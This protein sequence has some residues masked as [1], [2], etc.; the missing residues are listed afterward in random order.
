MQKRKIITTPFLEMVLISNGTH[1]TKCDFLYDNEAHQ[2]YKEIPLEDDPILTE[3]A[4]QLADY[5]AQK[6]HTFDLPLKPQGTNFQQKVW[7]VLQ[8][9][10]YGETLTYKE[11]ATKAGSPKAYQATGGACKANPYTIIIP[12]HRVLATTG[13]YTGYAGDKTFMKENLL[14]LES[15][16]KECSQ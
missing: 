4:N 10:P 14:N 6:R 8:T 12:C 9:I 16:K 15:G 7:Q 1:L 11:I 5:F 3:T 13:A 2:K